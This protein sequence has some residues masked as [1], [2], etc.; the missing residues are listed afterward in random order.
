MRTELG[1]ALFELQ[2]WIKAIAWAT[3]KF[4]ENEIMLK[5][6]KYLRENKTYLGISQNAITTLFQSDWA[7]EFLRFF[8]VEKPH[9]G[10]IFVISHYGKTADGRVVIL[11]AGASQE[12]Y[13]QYYR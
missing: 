13:N 3:R 2:E 5:A 9:T 1:F 12:V 8:K 11:D 10:D 7:K 6:E 4:S